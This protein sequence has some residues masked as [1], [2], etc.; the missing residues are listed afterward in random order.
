V[1]LKINW[2]A[3]N[4]IFKY[5]K[6]TPKDMLDWINEGVQLKCQWLCEKSLYMDEY[7]F[8]SNDSFKN[9]A[10]TTINNR[11]I[12]PILF[13][14]DVYSPGKSNKLSSATLSIV[15]CSGNYPKYSAE[16]IKQFKRHYKLK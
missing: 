14:S 4:N 6:S 16:I 7:Y 13:M 8:T 2:K 1:K 10:I 3:L 15:L 9:V 11:L 12:T 5:T